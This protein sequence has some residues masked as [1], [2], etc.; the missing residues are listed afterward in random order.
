[1]QTRC[2]VCSLQ[3]HLEELLGGISGDLLGWAPEPRTRA[4]KLL[5]VCLLCWEGTI[6]DHLQKLSPLLIKV[7]CVCAPSPTELLTNLPDI[8]LQAVQIS[9][10]I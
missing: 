3:A 6:D 4:A 9:L 10:N 8:Y 7:R 1:M 2:N 5:R